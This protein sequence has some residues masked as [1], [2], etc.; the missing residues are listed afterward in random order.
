MPTMAPRLKRVAQLPR[1]LLRY[2]RYD[3]RLTFWRQLSL[4]RR[5]AASAE[6]HFDAIRRSTFILAA[7]GAAALIDHFGGANLNQTVLSGFL[8]A[9]GAMT[10]ATI[11]LVFTISIFL[12]QNASDIYSS[13]YLEVYIHDWREKAI[14]FT[15]ILITIALLAGGLWVGS[16]TSVRASVQSALVLGSLILIAVVFAL[17]DWQY[18]LVRQKITPSTAIAFLEKKGAGFLQRV[19]YDAGKLAGIMQARDES[20]SHELALAAA[21]GRFLKPF[22]WN[23]DKQLENLIEISIKLAERHDV[24]AAKRGF[25]AACRL[26]KLYLDARRTSSLVMPSTVALLATESD[27]QPFLTSNCER[28]AAAA[29]RFIQDGND[30][31]AVHVVGVFGELAAQAQVVAFIPPRNENPVLDLFKSYLNV[32]IEH[33][34][35]ENNVEVVYQGVRVLGDVAEIAVAKGLGPTLFGLE[36][37][38]YAAAMFALAHK[39]TVVVDRCSMILVGIV[40]AA[41]RS[42]EV[43]RESVVA[44]VLRKIAGIAS[45]E[46]KLVASGVLPHDF[47]TS[48]SVTK[49][50][51]ELQSLLPSIVGRYTTQADEEHKARY[52]ADLVALFKEFNRSLRWL[53]EDLKSCD[54]ILIDSIG[55]LLYVVNMLIVHLIENA[56][57]AAERDELRNRLVWNVHLPSWFTHHAATFDGGAPPLGTLIDS[58]AKTGV[59][60]S[61]RLGDTQLVNECVNALASLTDNCLEKTRSSHGYD[62][63]RLMER[64]CYLGILGLRHGWRDVVTNV[65]V[66]VY[67]FE[68]KYCAK[69]L[70]HIPA[71]I[72]PAS[73]NVMGLPHSN[74]IEREL[75]RWRDDFARDCR[76]RLRIVDDA[77]TM[78]CDCVK[79]V[80]IDRFVFDVWGVWLKGTA[81]E[82]E[83]LLSLARK[84]LALELRNILA[85][86]RRT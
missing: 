58:V 14:Y 44:R 22:I 18:R 21:Y 8:V 61:E 72:D 85:Q 59:V 83:A 48:V 43:D 26:L 80:D 29:Q 23:L 73:H 79:E 68:P 13:Q 28:L 19:Q 27:S 2:L 17:I 32:V 57:F 7:A 30:D 40:D 12:L 55:H 67:E 56:E 50:Y 9:A 66:R 62:E 46:S 15:V 1:G 38:V 75:W 33:A 16:L 78:M 6:R 77:R 37:N 84:R 25:A 53:S 49:A 76:S 4:W 51:D 35:R 81:F 11:A 52:R 20:V 60:A 64:V 63:P 5:L 42:A 70:T 54:S 82:H 36:D 24:A 45:W 3:Y 39:Q 71:G 10:G 31:L 47:S 41:F 86:K 69:Y 65:G 34:Q 74:Q